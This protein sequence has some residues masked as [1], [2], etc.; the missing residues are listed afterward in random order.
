MLKAGMI[1]YG[2]LG[3]DIASLISD[4]K[5]K[6]QGPVHRHKTESKGCLGRNVTEKSPVKSSF[7]LRSTEATSSPCLP[8]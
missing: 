5:K 7:N 4:G 6:A 2:T 3:K 8:R 1:G